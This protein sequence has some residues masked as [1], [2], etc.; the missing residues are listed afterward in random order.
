MGVIRALHVDETMMHMYA[1]L[2]PGAGN[3]VTGVQVSGTVALAQLSRALEQL[4]Q[5]HA[6]LRVTVNQHPDQALKY[7]F[8]PVSEL[9]IPLTHRMLEHTQ[10]EEESLDSLG[11]HLLN[12]RFEKG[13]LLCRCELHSYGRQACRIMF[14][15]SHVICDGRSMWNL[16]N[17]LIMMIDG[18]ELEVLDSMSGASN[19]PLPLFDL[20]PTRFRGVG[21]LGRVLKTL[22]Y[23]MLLPI[24]AKKGI[25]FTHEQY[26][27]QSDRRCI[28]ETKV[29]SAK[30]FSAF[31]L[32]CIEHKI[33]LNS[34]L[35]A[36]LVLSFYEYLE[37]NGKLQEHNT[38]KGAALIPFVTTVDVRDK[39]K[40]A[41]SEKLTANYSAGIIYDVCV[42]VDD[43]LSMIDT[44][45]WTVAKRVHQQI[46]R[47]LQQDQLWR[48]LRVHQIA[49]VRGV[50]KAY[51]QYADSPLATPLGLA[52]FGNVHFHKSQKH[53]VVEIWG[54]GSFHAMG[55]GVNVS[56]SSF[57]DTLTVSVACASPLMS[58]KTLNDYAN[59][60]VAMIEKIGGIMLKKN[61][62]SCY[63]Q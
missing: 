24:R 3:L 13:A 12:H 57:N 25:S 19:V 52:H 7:V 61:A 33:S 18:I 11:E 44:G 35:T 46:K 62:C 56:I 50:K 43:V 38:R 48:I 63:D 39:V 8:T 55:A 37:S 54:L 29:I 4:Q 28:T 60:I 5:R 31:K 40:P 23:L 10:I 16:L 20:M 27:Q 36:A 59:S 21:G 53:Q 22:C 45:F 15:A 51:H 47:R 6:Y 26:A 30:D 9:A 42:S 58:R 34:C 17:E 1:G 49:G 32:A 14:C 2:A 41:Q